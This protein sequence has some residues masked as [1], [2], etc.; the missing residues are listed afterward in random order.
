LKLVALIVWGS[1]YGT[2]ERNSPKDLLDSL[3]QAL[4]RIF[5][6]CCCEP[7]QFCSGKGECG[8]DEDRTETFETVVKGA[9]VMP[10]FAADVASYW[11]TT[12]VENDA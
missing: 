4:S 11:P 9:W 6:L 10:I 8:G 2:Y 7:Y 1:R 3:R 12:A 5:G